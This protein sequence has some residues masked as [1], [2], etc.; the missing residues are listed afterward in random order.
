MTIKN[1]I[2]LSVIISLVL[3]A[4]ISVSII[5]SYMN[6][7]DLGEQES[8]AAGVVRGGYELTYLSNDYIINAEPRARTQWE[9]RYASLQPII[10]QLKAENPKEAKSIENIRN[11]NANMEILFNEMPEPGTLRTNATLFPAS[12]QQIAWSRMNAQSQGMIYEAWSLRYLYNDDIN[13]ARFWNNILVLVLMGTMLVII[14]VNYLLI[15]RR[16]VLSIK[17]VDA[18]SEAFAT[19]NLDYRIPVLADDEIGGIAYRLNK[20]AAQIQRVTAS[21]D[22]LNKEITLRKQM[23]EEILNLNQTLE[24]RIVQ[25]T[26]ELNASLEDKIVLLREV[27]HRVKNNFQII[28]SLFNLQSRYITDEKTRQLFNESQNRIRAMSIVHEKLHRS[29][30]IAR[31]DLD[32]YITFLGNS[33][34]TFYSMNKKGIILTT[35]IQDVNVTID[36]AIPIGL[37]INELISNSIK[38]AFPHSRN[39][40]IS[41]AIHRE[42]AHLTI[43][44]KDNGVGIPLDFDWRNAESLGLRLVVLLVEQMDGTIEL[45]RTN[46]TA[47]TIMVKEKE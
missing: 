1:Q 14:S 27:H 12:I 30:D 10:N 29:T 21:R 39:G 20:M 2:R 31:L 19:G 46:G 24:E 8:L 5:V 18:G 38:H 6:M 26:A 7:Q 47:F 33:L 44:Y 17:E 42:T 9:E 11:Y 35:D 36:T 22:E 43:T 28:I 40:E 3:V 23:E 25:R 13:E 41:I 34:F 15:S 16:L 37:I 32:N 45:D 4:V